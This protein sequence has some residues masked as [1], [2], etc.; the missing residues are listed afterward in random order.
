M[1][2]GTLEQG[3]KFTDL[4]ATK[5]ASGAHI[6]R[7]TLNVTMIPWERIPHEAANGI[8]DLAC[9]EGFEYNTFTVNMGKF[10]IPQQLELYDSYVD[11][12]T[13]NPLA[14]SSLIF[15]E[16]FGQQAVV[17]QDP[18]KTAAGNRDY[19]A[20]LA[21]LQTTYTDES[22]AGVADAWGR[23]W[24][25]DIFKPEHSGYPVESVYMNYAH[26][27]EPLQAMYGWEPWRLERLRSLKKRYDPHG[28]FNFY[29]SVL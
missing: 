29:N 22:V 9:T 12:V 16:V 21:V 15:Y 2:A 28:F 26:G 6:E 3:N 20:I 24:R 13:N 25:D 5:N 19:S 7:L 23:R 14:S 17:A 4:F 1:Y 8:I 11:L 10:D 27:D 18:A